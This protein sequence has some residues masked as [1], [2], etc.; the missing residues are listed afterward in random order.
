MAGS[1]GSQHNNHLVVYIP[2]RHPHVECRIAILG[3]HDAP[4][5]SELSKLPAEAKVSDWI[6][7]WIG[8]IESPGVI[9]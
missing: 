1:V 3:P 7:G 9:D 5:M 4:Y 6:G 2:H 8:G